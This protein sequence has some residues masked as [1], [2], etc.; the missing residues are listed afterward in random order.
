MRCRRNEIRKCESIKEKK[1][2]MKTIQVLEE[3]WQAV[4]N[5][6]VP[7]LVNCGLCRGHR[8]SGVHRYSVFEFTLCLHAQVAYIRGCIAGT[9]ARHSLEAHSA[10]WTARARGNRPEIMQQPN[11]GPSRLTMTL[12]QEWR[13]QLKC[14]TRQLMNEWET[15]KTE[16]QIARECSCVFT[17]A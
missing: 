4:R 5:T 11:L 13:R 17:Q 16:I 3:T 1:H 12:K 8:R 9:P 14:K 7:P 10:Y 2:N 15:Q 6:Y